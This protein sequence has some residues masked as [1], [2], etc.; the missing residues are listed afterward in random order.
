MKQ[1]P[2]KS[3]SPKKA[4]KTTKQRVKEH[5]NDKN[6]VITEEDMMNIKV[7]EDLPAG[8]PDQAENLAD[9][10]QEKKQISPWSIL[11]EEDK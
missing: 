10:I 5:I 11:S 2:G 8:A 7:P 1:N 9:A 6:D 3:Q 4:R